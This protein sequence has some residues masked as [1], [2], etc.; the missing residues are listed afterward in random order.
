MPVAIDLSQVSVTF[1]TGD[2]AIEAIN[3][4]S[5]TVREGEFVSLIGH[6]GCGKSTLL[7]VIADILPPTTGHVE[8]LGVAPTD[9][10]KAACCKHGL[11]AIRADALGDRVVECAHASRGGTTG[12]ATVRS[13]DSS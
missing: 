13:D 6:S 7:R 1:G 2:R 11:P 4:V 12:Q 9:A 8:V 3:E 10:R 5:L